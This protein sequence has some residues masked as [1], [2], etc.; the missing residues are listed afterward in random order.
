MTG[1]PKGLSAEAAE[2]V[3]RFGSGG[4]ATN[5]PHAS[6]QVHNNQMNSYMQPSGPILPDNVGM[7]HI[8]PEYSS[9]PV[10]LQVDTAVVQLTGS[11]NKYD[12]VAR[13]LTQILSWQVKEENLMKEVV[14]VIFEQGV[15]EANFRFTGGKLCEHLVKNVSQQ[16]NGLSFKS[17]LFRRCQEEFECR[18]EYQNI[19][20]FDRLIGYSFF[21]AEILTRLLT[22]TGQPQMKLKEALCKMLTLLLDIANNDTLKC[23]A[24]VLKM[25]GRFLEMGGSSEVEE[26][27]SKLRDIAMS[28]IPPTIKTILMSVVEFRAANWGQGPATEEE[29]PTENS[30]E[31]TT[32]ATNGD[33]SL[34][35][36]GTVFYGPGGVIDHVE[37]DSVDDYTDDGDETRQPVVA[38]QVCELDGEEGAAFDEFLM[39]LK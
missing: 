35:V 21:L 34:P 16:Y 6:Q 39:N 5:Q 9:H 30:G 36:L 12:A 25:S 1:K 3:P 37:E 33:E 23:V 19:K 4:G 28:P 24:Q 38:P 32:P 8:Q 18:H 2:F 10:I 27:M 29:K 11:P 20:C 17:L 22:P 31:T 7:I 13:Q 26:V 15:G 14:A